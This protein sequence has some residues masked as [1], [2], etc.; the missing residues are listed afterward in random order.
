MAGNHRSGRRPGPRAH[1]DEACLLL[2]EAV[3]RLDHA[4]ALMAEGVGHGADLARSAIA[5]LRVAQAL[6]DE[7]AERRRRRQ[8]GP[9]DPAPA[10]PALRRAA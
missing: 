6:D 4:R 10:A 5:E 3:D 2:A 8:A 1:R 9:H 7:L